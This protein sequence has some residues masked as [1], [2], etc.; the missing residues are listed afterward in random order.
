ML[1]LTLTLTPTPTPTLTLTRYDA[2]WAKVEAEW[3][4]GA[5]A[6]EKVQ[7]DDHHAGVLPPSSFAMRFLGATSTLLFSNVENLQIEPQP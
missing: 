2:S 3:H 7:A 4:M 5:T 6:C 1:T